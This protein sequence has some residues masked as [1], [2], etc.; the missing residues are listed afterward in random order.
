MALTNSLYNA[1]PQMAY[2]QGFWR[3]DEANGN[4]VDLSD[5]TYDLTDVNTVTS[6]T[7]KIGNARDFELANSEY[8]SRVYADCVNLRIAG[9]IALACWIKRESVTTGTEMAL[10]AKQTGT[11][12]DNGYILYIDTNDKLAL[13]LRRAVTGD[14]VTIVSTTALTST[15]VWY[16]CVGVLNQD[17]DLMQLYIN[18]V[19]D[20]SSGSHAENI[21]D[22][23][24]SPHFHIGVT[25]D[26]IG[27]L[28]KYYD[29]LIDEAIIWNT[30]LT[31]AEVAQVY[32]ITTVG[33][34]KKTN[35]MFLLNF[36]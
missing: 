29:G 14:S 24:N 28:R 18:G 5:N 6:A 30:Y 13:Q 1:L 2:I 35:P 33:Q 25:R 9:S 31:A 4:A 16:H 7:G 12:L 27:S 10:I 36:I 20:G 34:Y 23:G 17:T 8:F 22:Y 19:A 15:S 21:T 11:N 32:A 26:S 3:L